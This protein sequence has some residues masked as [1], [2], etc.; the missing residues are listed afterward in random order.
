MPAAFAQQVLCR[1][2]AGAARLRRPW[3][4]RAR[5]SSASPTPRPSPPGALGTISAGCCPFVGRGIVLSDLLH[6]GQGAAGDGAHRRPPPWT[7]GATPG[8]MRRRPGGNGATGAVL[9][10]GSG[11]VLWPLFRLV[12]VGQ[13]AASGAGD[14]RSG[15]GVRPGL[16]LAAG[17]HPPP[18]CSI[19]GCSCP[20]RRRPCPCPKRWAVERQPLYPPS[21]SLWGRWTRRSH[22]PPQ[23]HRPACPA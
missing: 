16:R 20:S 22:C 14:T 8:P 7:P 1:P 3:C 12:R 2:R 15:A 19:R 17:A 11:S 4:W 9:P 10:A 13:P 23:R 21:R 18:G 6:L 5:P